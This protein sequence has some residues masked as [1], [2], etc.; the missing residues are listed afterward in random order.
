MVPSILLTDAYHMLA[1]IDHVSSTVF[2][3]STI[4]NYVRGVSPT[5]SLFQNYLPLLILWK[6]CSSE[7]QS[8]KRTKPQKSIMVTW[9]PRLTQSQKGGKFERTTGPTI[10]LHLSA[11]DSSRGVLVAQGN[12]MCINSKQHRLWIFNVDFK[13]FQPFCSNCP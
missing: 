8:S 9:S 10:A 7:M 5:A 6:I 4:T 3:L 1:T 2:L 12:K 11:S 13:C